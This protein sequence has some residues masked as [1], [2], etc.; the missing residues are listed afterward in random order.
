MSLPS[1]ASA[2]F[3]LNLPFGV[4]RA[5]VPKF[6]WQWILA[7]HLPVPLIIALRIYSGIG[8]QFITFPI[9]IAAFFCGQFAGG[10]AKSIINFQ[11]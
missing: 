10:Q 1:V 3:L 2:V 6:S 11:K 5:S 4:W 8:W 7:I 9:L